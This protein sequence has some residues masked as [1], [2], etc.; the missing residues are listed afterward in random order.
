[1]NYFEGF[2]FIL[3]S[4]PTL[5]LASSWCC[6]RLAVALTRRDASNKPTGREVRF[7]YY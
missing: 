1:W 3:E 7:S 2:F 6:S 5:L 4:N